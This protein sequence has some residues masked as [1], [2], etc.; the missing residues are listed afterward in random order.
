MWN[1]EKALKSIANWC[2]AQPIRLCVLFGSQA[3]GRAQE[4]SDVDIAVWPAKSVSTPTR[5]SWLRELETILEKQVNMVLISAELDP[6]LGMEIVRHGQ[7]I[8]EREP[9][10]WLHHRS[11]LW[12]AYT[13]SL[14]FLRAARQQLRDFAEEVRRGK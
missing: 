10:A 5:L 13:D 6:V 3:T 11:Q 12:F 8:F 14:P 7:L 1:V 2:Q 9:D 4:H